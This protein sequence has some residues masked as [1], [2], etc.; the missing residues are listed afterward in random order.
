M[1]A[2]ARRKVA[3]RQPQQ[4]RARE[5]VSAI[6]DAV[7]RVLKR[8]G[9]AAVTTNRIAEVAGVSIGSV[10][11]YFPDKRA[12][13]VALHDRHRQQVSQ[14]V[15]T[16]LVVQADAPLEDL[17]RALVEA[18]IDAHAVDPEL[19]QLLLEVPHP[20]D[21]APDLPE[22]L[23][24]LMQPAIASRARAY[25]LPRDLD[26]ITFVLTHLIDTLGHAAVLGRPPRLSLAAARTEAVQAVLA[27]LR[28]ARTRPS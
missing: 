12:I 16:T 15:E 21:G 13:Y 18:L 27:Y 8:Q 1:Q 17:M 7:V 3:R 11:Q 20:S 14:L 4:R 9:I 2:R 26:K 10:Y 6:L 22:R 28:A 19:Y 5:T 25:G 24:V 23:R